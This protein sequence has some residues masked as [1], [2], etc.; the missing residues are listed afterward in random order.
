MCIKN[1]KLLIFCQFWCPCNTRLSRVLPGHQN[2]SIPE[3]KTEIE[4]QQKKKYTE[5]PKIRI[6]L[7]DYV[8]ILLK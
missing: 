7:W 3:N 4:F 6:A 8:C 5:I 2:P 1:S